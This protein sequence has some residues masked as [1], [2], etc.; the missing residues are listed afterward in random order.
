MSHSCT[1]CGLAHDAPL[2]PVVVE[3]G[4]AQ[5]DA[6]ESVAGA[7]VEVA[8]IQ[9]ERDIAVEKIRLRGL[10]EE[11]AALLAGMQARLD[12]LESARIQPE[13]EP[14][15]EPVVIPAEPQPEPESTPAP[16]ETTAPESR[17]PKKAGWWDGYAPKRG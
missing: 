12:V 6:A 15:P 7:E 10:D 8:R 2:P 17:G 16:P 5:A 14:L 1:E 11:T 13:P 3:D 9:A 4:S